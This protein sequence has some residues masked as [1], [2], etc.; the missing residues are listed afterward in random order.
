[1]EISRIRAFGLV[2][3]AVG[4]SLIAAPRFLTRTND[5]SF[6]L[7]VRT[8]GIRDL[9]LGAGSVLAVGEGARLWGA[10]T[11]ASDT[12]DVVAGAAAT[13]S[14]GVRGGLTAALVPVPFIAAGVWAMRGLELRDAGSAR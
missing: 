6:A 10:V 7:L 11:L 4:A 1:M 2:R 3:L 5:P 13:P 9:A 12:L 8:V 14:V